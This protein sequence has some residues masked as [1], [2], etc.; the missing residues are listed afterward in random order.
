MHS[1]ML[2]PLSVYVK[3]KMKFCLCSD[4]CIDRRFCICFDGTWVNMYMG[5]QLRP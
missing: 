3:K 5:F 4:H 2:V 1:L